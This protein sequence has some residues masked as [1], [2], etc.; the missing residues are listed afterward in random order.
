MTDKEAKVLK[1]RVGTDSPKNASSRTV[2]SAS[3]VVMS[4]V[5]PMCVSSVKVLAEISSSPG[6]FRMSIVFPTHRPSNAPG[7]MYSR[8][9]KL[10]RSSEL[11][12]KTPSNAFGAMYCRVSKS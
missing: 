11:L 5:P 1:F 6:L 9:S 3:F 2:L 10:Y 7:E 12:T 4:S 8:V